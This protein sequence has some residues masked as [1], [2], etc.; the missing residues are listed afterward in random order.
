M[1]LTTESQELALLTGCN[2]YWS[3]TVSKLKEFDKVPH[4]R[5]MVKINARG[6]Q[7]DAARWIRTG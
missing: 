1:D 4:E 3:D 2:S 7:G 5:L 6:I